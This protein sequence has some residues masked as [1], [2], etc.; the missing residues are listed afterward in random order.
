MAYWIGR[1]E[2][3]VGEQDETAWNKLGKFLSEKQLFTHNTLKS[4]YSL[5]Y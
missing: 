1:P 4:M 2:I 5:I 3:N